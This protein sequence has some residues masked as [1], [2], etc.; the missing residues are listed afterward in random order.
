MTA[1]RREEA[2]FACELD[3]RVFD[4]DAPPRA[5][6][7]AVT[8][9]DVSMSGICFQGQKVFQRDDTFDIELRLTHG[10]A[11][12][13]PLRL[14]ARVVWVTSVG[15]AQQIGAAFLDSLPA[16]TWARLDVI[17]KFLRGELE[18]SAKHS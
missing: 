14:S 3:A 4:L 5:L 15:D 10:Q 18:L 17:L 12:T 7:S 9:I 13:E 6:G 16:L 1:D 8:T 2:R 11:I